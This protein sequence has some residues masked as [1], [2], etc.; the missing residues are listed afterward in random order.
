MKKTALIMAGGRGE[1]FWPRSRRNLPKQ[2]LS[3]T[4]D[5]VTMIQHT[6]NRILPLVSAENIFISTNYEYVDIVRKQLPQVPLENILCEPVARN[7]APCIAFAAT[8]IKKK[9]GDALIIVLPSDHLI[10][11]KEMFNYTLQDACCVAE[12]NTNL[13]TIG[14][15]PTSPETGYGYIKFNDKR[16]DFNSAN[17]FKVDRFVE[18]PELDKAKDYLSSGSYLWNSG[19]FVWKASSI[20]RNI[21]KFLPDIYNGVNNIVNATGLENYKQILDKEFAAFDSISI[22]Y[23]VLEKAKNIFVLP[24]SFGWDDVGSWLALERINKTDD[25]K[26]VVDGN[27][28]TI[29]TTNSII[30]AK[31]KLVAAVGVEDLIIVDTDDALL[32]CRKSDAG[33]IKKILENLKVCNRKEYL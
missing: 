13:A 32:V 14:V 16:C 23:G 25:Y 20:L 30:Q 15:V 33:K 12:E 9:Y 27:V 11:H 18:K 22:D 17:A 10:M 21:Q 1:R 2:F 19:M 8:H 29:D 6:V 24:G 31:E 4:N 3:L 7:T 26:N 28:I 5:G